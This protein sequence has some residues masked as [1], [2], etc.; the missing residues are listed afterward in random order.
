MPFLARFQSE[1]PT[2][3]D[4]KGLGLCRGEAGAFIAGHNTAPGG[5]LP[6]NTNGGGLSYM[7]T[8]ALLSPTEYTTWTALTGYYVPRLSVVV[9][10]QVFAYFFLRLYR[11]GIYEIKYF[12]NEITNVQARVLA[13]QSG[14]ILNDID[15]VKS[16]CRS[17]MASSLSLLDGGEAGAPRSRRANAIL[18][19]RLALAKRP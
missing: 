19:A 16:A 4:L 11:S 15:I 2:N 18:A 7:G 9:F 12:Q 17:L 1:C 6:L 14:L 10:L 13:L 3:E 8:F 5:R